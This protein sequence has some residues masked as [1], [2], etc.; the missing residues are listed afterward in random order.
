MIGGLLESENENVPLP[1]SML[2]NSV[3]MSNNMYYITDCMFNGLSL[4]PRMNRMH[5]GHT[6]AFIL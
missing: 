4:V 5:T 2:S 6:K 3:N 1:S